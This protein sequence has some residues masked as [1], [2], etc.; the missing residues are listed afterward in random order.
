MSRSCLLLL[1]A[2]LAAPAAAQTI[3]SSLVGS[4]KDQSGGAVAGAAV[5]LVQT[6]TAAERKTAT[7]EL[8]DFV[9]S[10]LQPGEYTLFVEHAGFR[11]VEKTNIQVTAAERHAVGD[12]V[13]LVGAVADQMM[14][15]A[16]G[17]P[18]QTASSERS[19]VITGGQVQ[20][21]LVQNRKFTSLLELLPGVNN[22]SSED[23][24]NRTFGNINVNGQ[25][26]D[27]TNF[28]IDGMTIN[29]AGNNTNGVVSM[30]MDA[31]SEVKV[32]LSNYQAEYGVMSGANVQLVTKSGTREFHGLASYFKRHEELNANNF[33]NNS[34][35]LP[36]PRYRYNTW[37]Y[38]VG[39]PVY[40]P[41]KFN[42]D[43]DKLFFFWSQEFW[44]VE[45][46]NALQ[47]LTVPTALE[48][49]GDFSQSRDLNGAL[50]PVVDPITHQP[51]QGNFIPVSRI[52]K[53][54]Q[55]LLS[56]LPQPNLNPNLAGGRNYVFQNSV[57]SPQRTSTLKVDYNINSH[58]LISTNLTTYLDR[59]QG[60]VGVQSGTS[61][62]PQISKELRNSGLAII[63]RYQHIFSPSL[64][65][66]LNVSASRRPGTITPDPADL[67]RNQRDTAGFTAG[68]FNAAN[69]PLNLI[70]NATF[71]G[72]TGAA[73]LQ[74]EGRFPNGGTH[75]TFAIVNN[76]TKVWSTHTIKAGIYVDHISTINANP[77][78]FN[79]TFDFGRNVNNPQDT[80]YAYSNAALGIFNTYTE[81]L[82]RTA[83]DFIL[84][85]VE[86]FVQ[87]NWK[88]THNLT[89]D[90]GMRF[91]WAPPA[92]ERNGVLSGFDKSRFDP[93][94]TVQL[95]QSRTVNGQRVGVNPVSGQVYPAAQI[96]LIAPNTGSSINGL[97]S[98]VIDAK[99]PNSLTSTRGVQ[100]APRLGFAWDPFGNGKTAFR[101]GFG[102]FYNRQ[103]LAGG[104]F[105]MTTQQPLVSNPVVYYGAIS[106]LLQSSGLVS[107]QSIIGLDPIGKI[108]TVMNYSIAL[109]RSLW[110]GT[111]VD[112]AYVGSLG[113]H[114]MWQRNLNAIP[115]GT[116]FRPSSADPT[117]PRATL[118]PQFLRPYIGFQDISMREWGSSSNY[119]SLQVTANRRF[120]KNLQFGAAWT[121]SKAMG[122][123]DT[124]TEAVSTL[125]DPRVWNYGLAAF[126]R[127]HI[128]KINWL[129]D[130]RKLPVR[131]RVL[132]QVV[133]Y[134]QLSGVTSFISGPPVAVGLSTVTATDITGS[135]TDLARV[136]VTGNPVL[137]MSERSLTRFFRTDVFQ[138]PAIGTFGNA[139]RTQLRGPGINNWDMAIFKNFPIHEQVRLQFRCEMYNAW[140]HTQFSGL[141][142]G[143]RFDAQGRQVNARFGQLFS[144]RAPR[145]IQLALRFYF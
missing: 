93:S 41:G 42:R 37:N 48:R 3:T 44:P 12:I 145:Q 129:W 89:L 105:N 69:N 139:G 49:Q 1:F 29:A 85:N 33:F 125:I 91:V 143:A 116:D 31:I 28:T 84:G 50:I 104:I 101:G 51:F 61:N 134:W 21:L 13:L 27:S 17:A 45:N 73:N 83:P 75:N 60:S 117:N 107:P 35:G 110:G 103:S 36:K 23:S 18:V 76:L 90:F 66:E 113:R 24:L 5:T 58:N 38:S 118:Q 52:D 120:T 119:H 72:V 95:I 77:I 126:D 92:I 102:M 25:R 55:A 43:R 87:D 136:V 86:W 81:T 68:Q 100:Y 9:F 22:R 130:S 121:W 54:G 14:V 65:D 82:G 144:A 132:S 88:L 133:N 142:A 7:N 94:Q 46:T 4:V 96:G 74:I 19:G 11:R 122:Y 64:I 127:T 141:D 138:I 114:L 30:S 57:K 62:W 124:D 47:Q 106:T 63:T 108:P 15:T 40:I 32:L 34:L 2:C 8:G 112:V 115:F 79:G 140:N 56:F 67:K 20:N 123:A 78:S 16:Q 135:P 99:I 109:Q 131:S 71:G 97:V 137:P 39:G 6:A 128:V 26:Q 70:P 98:P 10:S 53:S 59:Q 80:G 111:V